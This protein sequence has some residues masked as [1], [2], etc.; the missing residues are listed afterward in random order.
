MIETALA[1]VSVVIS[2]VELMSVDEDSLTVYE[3]D[4]VVNDGEETMM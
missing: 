2:T 3:N 1:V 4:G